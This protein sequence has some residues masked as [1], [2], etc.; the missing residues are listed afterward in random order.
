MNNEKELPYLIHHL[1]IDI[2][3]INVEIE[4]IKRDVNWIKNYVGHFKVKDLSP[5]KIVVSPKKET[6]NDS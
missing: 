4:K 1:Q 5:T 3:L 2:D 6:E